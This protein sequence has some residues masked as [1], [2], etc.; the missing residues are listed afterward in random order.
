M[1]IK[2]LMKPFMLIGFLAVLGFKSFSANDT[3]FV[4]RGNI[5]GYGDGKIVISY[6]NPLQRNEPDTVEIKNDKFIYRGKL[7]APMTVFARLLN[8]GTLAKDFHIYSIL[9][10]NADVSL[11]SDVKNLRNFSVIGSKNDALSKKIRKDSDPLLQEFLKVEK[12]YKALK[13]PNARKELEVELEKKKWAYFS[14][15]LG[16][17]D[18]YNSHAGASILWI[19]SDKRIP[20]QQMDSI[21]T[22]FNPSVHGSVYYQHM[23]RKVNA[24]KMSQPGR[25][26][27]DF[28]VK[29]LD[30]KSYTLGDYSGNY[31]LLTF[32]ASWCVPCKYEYPYLEKA[33][34]KFSGKG[35]QVV[36]LNLDDAREKWESD[37]KKYNFPF[38]VLSN[39]EAFD[40]TLTKN[41]GVMSIPKIFLISP[42]G[43]ILSATVR[44][45]RILDELE[46]IYK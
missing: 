44:Q 28:L 25:K 43:E 16:S 18:F 9:M 8:N 37:V 13:D 5:T 15:L 41:Y 12:E 20:W 7:D 30:G 34:D 42:E 31:L 17:K 46:N 2:T 32:S 35:L 14:Y 19:F 21:L 38:P 23:A 11:N 39:L 22:L 24:A 6:Y 40:G 1:K 26:A 4:L 27:S 3:S 36:I 33:Y 29:D 10:E 45:Q